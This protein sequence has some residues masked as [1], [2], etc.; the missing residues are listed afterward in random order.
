MVYIYVISVVFPPSLTLP[1]NHVILFVCIY[2]YVWY[3]DQRLE[4][5]AYLCSAPSEPS[6]PVFPPVYHI[7]RAKAQRCLKLT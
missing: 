2:R 7:Q 3:M 4:S 6:G 5:Q 1:P